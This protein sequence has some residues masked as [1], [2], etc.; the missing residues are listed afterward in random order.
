M[1]RR[2]FYISDFKIKFIFQKESILSDTSLSTS[3]VNIVY[4]DVMS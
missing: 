4:A 3:L 1:L 2:L